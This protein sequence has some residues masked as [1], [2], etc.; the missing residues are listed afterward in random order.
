MEDDH[1][2]N[3]AYLHHFKPAKY[4]FPPMMVVIAAVTIG[5][6]VTFGVL[7]VLPKPK[8]NTLLKFAQ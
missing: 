2:P 3:S 5:I 1:S 4:E 7:S 8:N 6:V